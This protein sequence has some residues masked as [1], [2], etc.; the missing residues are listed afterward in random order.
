MLLIF[1]DYFEGHEH[2]YSG[3]HKH[4]RMNWWA[5]KLQ[6]FVDLWFC[7]QQ[8]SFLV[9][10]F[11]NAKALFFLFR[12]YKN[13]STIFHSLENI[14]NSVFLSST[15]R[16]EFMSDQ[17]NWGLHQTEYIFV[18]PVTKAHSFAGLKSLSRDFN[19]NSVFVFLS[20]KKMFVFFLVTLP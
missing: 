6:L 10:I 18:S 9:S 16:M 2:L 4:Q 11:W 17:I 13:Q 1:L 7:W 8:T 3:T 15:F 19:F 20:L 5:H 14:L 12:V